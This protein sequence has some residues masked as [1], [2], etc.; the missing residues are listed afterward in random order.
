[1]VKARE[2]FAPPAGA[3][4]YR[5]RVAASASAAFARRAKARARRRLLPAEIQAT[6]PPRTN[7][8]MMLTSTTANTRNSEVKGNGQKFTT[9]SA[10]L[11]TEKT[12]TASAVGTTTNQ[13]NNLT[14][15][16]CPCVSGP[17]SRAPPAGGRSAGGFFFV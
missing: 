13:D 11:D 15:R 1:M 17:A 7:P 9:T 10:R 16:V 14:M 5:R 2:P 12:T 6:R 8:A 3:A 4:D